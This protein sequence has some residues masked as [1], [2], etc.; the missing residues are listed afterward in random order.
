MKDSLC[1]CIIS[2]WNEQKQAIKKIPAGLL[3]LTQGAIIS[4]A[5]LVLFN[6]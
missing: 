4:E 3:P 2:S 5:N 6:N 1:N